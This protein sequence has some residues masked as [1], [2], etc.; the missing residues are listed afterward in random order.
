MFALDHVIAAVE[1][2]D[3]W[4][5]RVRA[6]YG[7]GATGGGRH[8]DGT[9]NMAVPLGGTQYLEL[10][11]P[12][13]ASLSIGRTVMRRLERGEGWFGWALE[14]SDLDATAARLNLTISQGSIETRDGQ[15]GSW[16]LAGIE[17]AAA[18]DG[19]LP[20]FIEYGA[21]DRS[22]LWADRYREAEHAVP[23]IGID[24]VEVSFDA[25]TIHRWLAGSDLP[26]RVIDGRR[27][28]CAVGIKCQKGEVTVV[29]D[30][31]SSI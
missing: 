6:R 2:L 7:W 14:D 5:Q 23:P 9:E 13:D 10:I 21:A 22:A 18:S 29:R 8:P 27:G 4:S 30:W 20:F 31:W 12:Y 28:L 11:T 1:S 24:S 26:V 19:A 15:I 3:T 25:E 17:Q 16:R